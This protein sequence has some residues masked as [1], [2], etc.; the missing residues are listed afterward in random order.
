M[1]TN[2]HIPFVDLITPH[3]ELEEQLLAVCRN[4]LGT[5][6]FIGGPAVEEFENQFAEYCQVKHC[7][8]VGSGTD[9]LRFALMASGVGPG[10]LVITVPNT[11]IA[12]AEAIS[13]TG[14][15]PDFVDV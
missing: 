9:A 13:Q 3:R 8:G 15:M 11:F 5:G 14:A 4:A 12:T 1:T 2:T 10:D 7:V 6:T